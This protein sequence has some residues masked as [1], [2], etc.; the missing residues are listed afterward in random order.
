MESCGLSQEITDIIKS[1]YDNLKSVVLLN[2]TK[3]DFV[4]TTVGIQQGCLLSPVLFNIFIEKIMHQ[5]FHQ[6]KTTI[7]VG[8]NEINNLR[9]ADGIDLIAASTAELQT[10]TSKLVSASKEY[11]M[12]MSKEKI[13]TIVNSVNID[14]QAN[15]LMELN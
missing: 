13:K 12:E 6:T 5:M 4:H 1:L 15:I 14:D 7:S 9:F 10:L 8:G 11:G 2:N 3:G